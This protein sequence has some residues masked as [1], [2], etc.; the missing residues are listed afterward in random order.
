MS[1]KDIARKA[2]KDNSGDREERQRQRRRRGKVEPTTYEG[3]DKETGT[4]ITRKVGG[5]AVSGGD[6]ITT[7]TIK[8][9]RISLAR[10]T[11]GKT[12]I[13][14]RPGRNGGIDC[15]EVGQPKPRTRGTRFIETEQDDPLAEPLP[16]EE[17]PSQAPEDGTPTPGG[18]RCV[19]FAYQYEV[20]TGGVDENGQWLTRTV[21][22]PNSDQ[23]KSPTKPLAPLDPNHDGC[24]K[25]GQ[26]ETGTLKRCQWY[27]VTEAQAIAGEGAP[28]G[29]FVSGYVEF[30]EGVFRIL[31][32]MEEDE[33]AEVAGT[34][35]EWSPE[36]VI[37]QGTAS[38]NV[39]YCTGIDKAELIVE[40]ES[41]TTDSPPISY[42]V[43]GGGGIEVDWGGGDIDTLTG[44]S[45]TTQKRWTVTA[46][47]YSA[48]GVSFPLS[49]DLY[50]LN[51]IQ[52]QQR[53]QGFDGINNLYWLTVI[54]DGVQVSDSC[55]YANDG[56]ATLT[57]HRVTSDT[58]QTSERSIATP[59][60]VAFVPAPYSVT[61]S[62]DNGAIATRE[63]ETEPANF[64][65]LCRVNTK[66]C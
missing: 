34:G 7:G 44:T 30:P 55:C 17:I 66:I 8:K 27:D 56:L 3:H 36:N 38:E 28:D 61:V 47:G 51:T 43:A 1:A 63:F 46:T 50:G 40:G 37:Q 18:G 53:Y 20:Y 13:D 21:T 5:D 35:R 41:F 33:P 11:Q 10:T 45:W 9:G 49:F 15:G 58:A 6:K 31:A 12:R 65:Y 57:G 24:I 25:P 52:I 59:P 23:C 26:A 2:R 19:G 39:N 22:E 4:S 42:E 14:A 29:M 64:Y 48:P 32:C 54:V 62:D 60:T 16:E